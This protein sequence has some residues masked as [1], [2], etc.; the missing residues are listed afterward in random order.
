MPKSNAATDDENLID[1]TPEV[2]PDT[3][4]IDI[5]ED[6]PEGGDEEQRG[7]APIAAAGERQRDDKTGQWSRK[8]GEKA[9]QKREQIDYNAERAQWARDREQMSSSLA[10][11]RGRIEQMSRQPAP[12]QQ[13]QQQDPIASEMASVDQQILA[14]L[15]LL[16]SDPKHS[17]ERYLKLQR[18]SMELVV[19]NALRSQQGQQRQQPEQRSPYAARREI[20]AGEHPWMNDPRNNPLSQRAFARRQYLIEGEGRPDTIETDRE[21][22]SWAVAN[23]GADFGLR[24]PAAPTPRTRAAW[25]APGF[26]DQG[27]GRERDD[28]YDEVDVPNTLLRGSGLDAQTLGRVVREAVRGE[29]GGRS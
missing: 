15:K 26:R 18:R 5:S 27:R 21:A 12:G 16:E 1:A 11:L 14:E 28:G 3:T 6:E 17:T 19:A 25:Q 8:K 29:R 22:L 13:S 24:Q 4:R 9:R 20:L 7:E 2:P 23:F 10:E